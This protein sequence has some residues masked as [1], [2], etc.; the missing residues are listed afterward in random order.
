MSFLR[1]DVLKNIFKTEKQVPNRIMLEDSDSVPRDAR[2][3][4]ELC[5]EPSSMQLLQAGPKCGMQRGGEF[6][7]GRLLYTLVMYITA[8][9][10]F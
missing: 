8:V 7:K 1:P 9:Q 3:S 6:P 5:T 4:A 10:V 2:V